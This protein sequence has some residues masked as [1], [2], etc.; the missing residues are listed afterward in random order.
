MDAVEDAMEGT[1]FVWDTPERKQAYATRERVYKSIA[2]A[3]G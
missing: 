3:G 2:A 1:P